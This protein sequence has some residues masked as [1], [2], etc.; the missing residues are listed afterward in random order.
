[1]DGRHRGEDL[2]VRQRH[3]R[4]A[5]AVG[6]PPG[7]TS[8]PAVVPDV[9]PVIRLPARPP[10]GCRAA[11]TPREGATWSMKIRFA[12]SAGSTSRT[13]TAFGAEVR[14]RA[15]GFDTMWLSD[16]PLGAGLDPLVGLS[17]AAAATSSLKLGA[18]LVPIGRN[19]LTLA[20]SLAQIDQLSEGR[21]LLSFVV[22]L[23]QPGERQALGSAGAN[24]GRLIEEVTPLLRTWWAGESGH[25]R[26]RPVPLR[27]RALA[28]ALPTSSPWKC[29]SA[30][31]GRPPWTAPVGWRTAGWDRPCRRPRAGWPGSASSGRRRGG[32]P[33]RPRALRAQRPLRAPTE[34]DQRLHRPLRARRPDADVADLIPVGPAQLR[35]L[36]G[37]IRRRRPVEVR[38][39]HGRA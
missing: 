35:R 13:S 26:Q 33:D 28:G 11:Q 24:R 17:F 8:A 4:S 15:L 30:G 1:M 32:R 36:V 9:S 23:D 37:R 6:R 14:R 2:G 25:L 10:P 3:R 31:A 7:P 20:K 34:P 22:G 38:G 18:N 19:P 27:P 29:G 5:L 21:L 12:V 39:A 16:I